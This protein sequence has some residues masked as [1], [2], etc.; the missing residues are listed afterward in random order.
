MHSQKWFHSHSPSSLTQNFLFVL[1]CSVIQKKAANP[2]PDVSNLRPMLQEP[3]V[4][5]LVLPAR[6]ARVLPQQFDLVCGVPSVPERIAEILTWACFGLHCL[7][8][9]RVVKC[10]DKELTD[11][12]CFPT[13][14]IKAAQL[15]KTKIHYWL[16]FQCFLYLQLNTRFCDCS[17]GVCLPVC[18]FH[19]LP[20]DHIKAGTVLVAKYEA[21]IIIICGSIDM[22]CAL[23]VHS[24]ECCITCSW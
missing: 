17:E 2:L 3:A 18:L 21:S 9:R 11:H 1:F 20:H 4:R 12:S 23:K 24:I 7:M 8:W 22:E 19:L 6:V 10:L 16:H 15:R 13:V 14:C 5:G